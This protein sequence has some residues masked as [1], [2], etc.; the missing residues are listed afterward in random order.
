MNRLR[1]RSTFL[2][3]SV[4]AIGLMMLI[5]R[6]AAANVLYTG[7]SGTDVS[8]TITA[9]DMGGVYAVTAPFTL[10]SASV[11]DQFTFVNWGDVGPVEPLTVSWKITTSPGSGVL[12]SGNNAPVSN[13]AVLGVHNS[14]PEVDSTVALPAVQLAAGSYWLQLS[15]CSP[16]AGCGWGSTDFSGP[17]E[18]L[19][20]GIVD[21]GTRAT[22]SFVIDGSSAGGNVTPTPEPGYLAAI[23]FMAIGMAAFAVRKRRVQQVN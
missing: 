7:G 16:E 18:Q 17:A 2:P 23:A 4:A 10:S 5:A 14:Y 11:L 22:P 21:D 12:F 6:P 20:Y 15:N 1:Y 19:L 8:P 3:G 13:S 9:P